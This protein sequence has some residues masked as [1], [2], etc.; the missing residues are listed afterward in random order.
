MENPRLRRL[1][2]KYWFRI[3]YCLV[4]STI[5]ITNTTCSC[6]K[7][8]VTHYTPTH[9]MLGCTAVWQDEWPGHRRWCK[10]IVITRHL[11]GTSTL[12]FRCYKFS[13]WQC[14]LVWIKIIT[15]AFRCFPSSEWYLKLCEY[16][17]AVNSNERFL[18]LSYS[19]ELYSWQCGERSGVRTADTEDRTKR[20]TI[21]TDTGLQG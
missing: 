14:A 1:K 13:Y 15:G 19:K 21:T 8:V 18:I 3:C 9:H 4:R 5:L 17:C 16:L 12:I 6:H 2:C 7:E 11:S 20:Q 10:F